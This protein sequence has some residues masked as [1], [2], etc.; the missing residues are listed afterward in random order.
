MPDAP[1]PVGGLVWR[2]KKGQNVERYLELDGGILSLYKSQEKERPL[3]AVLCASIEHCAVGATPAAW[4]LTVD[5]ATHAFEAR[6]SPTAAEW[7]RR[8]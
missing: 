5:G 7:A 3:S 2:D 8:R 4:S 6:G 1:S